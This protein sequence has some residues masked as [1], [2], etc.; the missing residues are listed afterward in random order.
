MSKVTS[1]WFHDMTYLIRNLHFLCF[2]FCPSGGQVENQIRPIIDATHLCPLIHHPTK[3]QPKIISC[4]E[5]LRCIE[6]WPLW[7]WKLVTTLGN[8][9]CILIIRAPMI[10]YQLQKYFLIQPSPEWIFL[11]TLDTAYQI[12]LG[13]P[14]PGPIFSMRCRAAWDCDVTSTVDKCCLLQK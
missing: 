14:V 4:I 13:S 3:Y 5:L 10:A 12:I 8:M 7:P 9:S 2:R 6:L 11:S 1:P